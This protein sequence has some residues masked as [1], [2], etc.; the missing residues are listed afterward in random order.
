LALCKQAEASP[1]E[2][3]A[4]L[5][6]DHLKWDTPFSQVLDESEAP[7]Y[8]WFGDGELHV[9]ANCLDRHLNTPTA[10]KTALIFDSDDG[11]VSQVTYKEL[12]ARVCEFANGLSALGHTLGER[13]IIYM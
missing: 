3:W 10:N 2:F 9:S 8:R 11:K 1:D 6:R 4:G 7:F 12:H 5:A 13:A